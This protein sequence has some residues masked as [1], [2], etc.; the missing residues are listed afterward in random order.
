MG[1]LDDVLLGGSP[2]NSTSSSD[3]NDRADCFAIFESI[4]ERPDLC[5][6]T[7]TEYQSQLSNHKVWSRFEKLDR[8]LNDMIPEESLEGDGRNIVAIAAGL[9]QTDHEESKATGERNNK[10]AHKKTVTEQATVNGPPTKDAHPLLPRYRT[11]DALLQ[12]S[13]NC[14]SAAALWQS[15][16]HNCTK[17]HNAHESPA[18]EDTSTVPTHKQTP[19]GRKV[20]IL[21]ATDDA[22]KSKPTLA[23]DEEYV[24]LKK[25]AAF[26]MNERAR[27]QVC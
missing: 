11:V 14:F 5:H 17:Q 6:W 8:M 18:A 24:S 15:R 27:F 1:L 19:A 13:I 26:A 2:I 22:E 4:L 7:T 21:D 16:H 20:D 10:K 25:K 12:R 23:D 9:S 3:Q